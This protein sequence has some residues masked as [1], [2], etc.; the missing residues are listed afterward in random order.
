LLDGCFWPSRNVQR[1]IARDRCRRGSDGDALTAAAVRCKPGENCSVPYLGAESGRQQMWLQRFGLDFDMAS[2][3]SPSTLGL[4][5]L[6]SA[7]GMPPVAAQASAEDLG[8]LGELARARVVYAATTHCLC[9][10]P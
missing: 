3:S 9:V 7:S 10:A 5:T 2:L 8:W 6:L 1:V 4:Q